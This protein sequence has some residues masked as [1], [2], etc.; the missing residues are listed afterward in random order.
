MSPD[1]R[2]A[3]TAEELVASLRAYIDQSVEANGG[4]TEAV[5]PGAREPFHWPPPAVSYRYHLHAS[6]WDGTATFEAH[7]ETFEVE[8]AHTPYGVFGRCPRIW[9]EDR[10][11]SVPEMLENLRQSSEPLFSRQFLISRCLNRE[12]RYE[13]HISDL[14]ADDLVKLLYCPD[15]DIAHQASGII[16]TQASLGIYGPVLIEILRDRRH[17]FRRSA[18]WEAL[19]LFE[20]LPSFCHTDEEQREAVQAMRDLL[21][22]AEDDFARTIYKAGVVLGGHLPADLG[23]PV[24]LECLNAPSKIG[25]RA[26]IHGLF[27]VVEWQPASRDR[28]VAALRQV[29]GSDPE[30]LLRDYAGDMACDIQNGMTDHVMEPLFPEETSSGD[31]A[32]A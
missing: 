17:P 26:A 19:D 3:P 25:R 32:T 15:R 24:L 10:G 20:D 31:L 27:H 8:V 22:D 14:P 12:G 21:W 30:P 18:Q 5:K 11:S 16:E 9:H 13:G 1:D 23:G 2:P 28:V 29:E 6:D 7:G 4:V